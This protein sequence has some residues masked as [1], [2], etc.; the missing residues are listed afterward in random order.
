MSHI[1]LAIEINF[2]YTVIKFLIGLNSGLTGIVK[3]L[4]IVSEARFVPKTIP[5]FVI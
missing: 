2:T 1:A 4:G 5:F 3:V